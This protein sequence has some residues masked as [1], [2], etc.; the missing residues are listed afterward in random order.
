MDICTQL[1]DAVDMLGK[2]MYSALFYLNTKH[3]YLAFPDDVM[4]RP[5]DLKVQP[6]RD[7]PAT[8]KANQQELARDIVGQVKQIEQ[9]VQ[10]LPGLTSTEA[11]QIQRVA[12]LEETL[13]VVEA[14]HH[15]VL[16]EREALQAQTEAVILD[17]TI[18]MRTAGDEA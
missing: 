1:Q 17:C 3:D 5:P 4:A 14:R 6:E 10:A 9:L 7:E 11:E 16:K 12:A 13:R 8:F 2:E 18:R 15:E